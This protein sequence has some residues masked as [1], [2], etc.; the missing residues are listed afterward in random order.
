[1]FSTIEQLDT[2]G[3][4]AC[5]HREEP[6]GRARAGVLRQ[7]EGPR[8]SRGD[9]RAAQRRT[10]RPAVRPIGAGNIGGKPGLN[11]LNLTVF[12][13]VTAEQLV[14]HQG[15]SAGR[16]TRRRAGTTN[17]S[18]SAGC[19][20]GAGRPRAVPRRLVQGRHAGHA[21][22]RDGRERSAREPAQHAQ[23]QVPVRVPDRDLPLPPGADH[24]AAVAVRGSDA[25][26]PGRARASSR[27]TTAPT[28]SS[29]TDRTCCAASKS[30]RASRSSTAWASSTTSGSTWTRR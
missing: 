27:S 6:R 29:A 9:A 14:G 17:V 28:C 12:Y 23:R 24:R 1:M 4:V 16:P 19:G 21:Q 5:R 13:H 3:I 11:P 18:R 10:G 30:T 7:P 2:A 26:L 25:G 20:V 15:R 8:R 22:L